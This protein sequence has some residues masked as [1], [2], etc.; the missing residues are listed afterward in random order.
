[1]DVLANISRPML[2]LWERFV[3]S[4][5][6]LFT[7]NVIA[8]GRC[9]WWLGYYPISKGC[10]LWCV[11]PAY[12][13]YRITHEAPHVSLDDNTAISEGDG[14]RSPQFRHLCYVSSHLETP[15]KVTLENPL[16][17]LSTRHTLGEEPEE[18]EKMEL[19]VAVLPV[20]KWG[21]GSTESW[22]NGGPQTSAQNEAEN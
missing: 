2:L 18:R 11:F 8:L 6:D 22:P 16:S 15:S 7:M 17:F 13:E 19:M 10:P 4:S 9:H 5:P 1:M 21:W 3:S 20:W 14:N 12:Q